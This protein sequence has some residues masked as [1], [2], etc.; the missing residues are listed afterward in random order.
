MKAAIKKSADGKATLEH[1]L[2]E[3]EEEIDILFGEIDSLQ[4]LVDSA[5][6][7]EN[8][9][10]DYNDDRQNLIAELKANITKEQN[11][12]A[13]LQ[14]EMSELKNTLCNEKM[15]VEKMM[16]ESKEEIEVL[17]REID[18]LRKLVHNCDTSN[19]L[20]DIIDIAGIEGPSLQENIDSLEIRNHILEKQIFE[21]STA[22]RKLSEE[23]NVEAG[24]LFE[25]IDR[26]QKL[27]KEK[28]SE[29]HLIN[30]KVECL[31]KECAQ[32][33][34]QGDEKRRKYEEE[35][36]IQT[37]IIRKLGEEKKTVEV[38]L[39]LVIDSQKKYEEQA[40]SFKEEIDSYRNVMLENQLKLEEAINMHTEYEE[41]I[42][43][44]EKLIN[45][46]QMRMADT[47]KGNQ[48]LVE[49]NEESQQQ[50]ISVTQPSEAE[51]QNIIERESTCE[52]IETSQDLEV[53]TEPIDDCENKYGDSRETRTH[54]EPT[55]TSQDTTFDSS[56]DEDMFL[57]NEEDILSNSES[58]G[59]KSDCEN[60]V[61]LMEAKYKIEVTKPQEIENSMSRDE[62]CILLD[63]ENA[64]PN[65]HILP[66]AK[67]SKNE[68]K[69][70]DTRA[71]LQSKSINQFLS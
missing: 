25:E 49:R 65:S 26:L 6:M 61:E 66:M 70:K 5:K 71:P 36:R 34:E 60:K 67:K 55:E 51:I 30:S 47:G 50:L 58:L 1:K 31:K 48:L 56:F 18:L 3:S 22:Q 12:K 28:R 7:R 24:E 68:L 10:N 39:E 42:D 64:H 35:T 40:E 54:Q 62:V 41:Q 32:L 2:S 52:P 53:S 46:F 19:K 4:K 27:V 33:T 15:E 21:I 9:N 13:V 44:Y 69:T 16:Y 14:K 57:P 29:K 63:K 11:E 23:S 43:M 59:S 38:Q 37:E 45:E 17:L 20:K 8:D